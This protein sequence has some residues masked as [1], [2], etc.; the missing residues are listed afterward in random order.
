MATP[1]LQSSQSKSLSISEM[2]AVDCVSSR[3]TLFPRVGLSR[4]CL[5]GVSTA[6]QK[7]ELSVRLVVQLHHAGVVLTWMAAFAPVILRRHSDRPWALPGVDLYLGCEW[8][9]F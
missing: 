2:V 5:P 3:I 7:C 1:A 9:L 4:G 8:H 6:V